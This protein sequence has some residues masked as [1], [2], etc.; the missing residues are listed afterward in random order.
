M[1]KNLFKRLQPSI[2]TPSEVVSGTDPIVV[3]R[4]E[5]TISRKQISKHALTVIYE[6][7]RAGH[8]AY[9]VGGGVRDLLRGKHPKD[10]DVATDAT[11]EQVKA[12]FQ[13]ARIVGRRAGHHR[14][15]VDPALHRFDQA[16]YDFAASRVC[17]G[18][19]S[20]LF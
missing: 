13:R 17:A 10:F 3:E 2:T 7:Q 5:H 20:V 19:R 14:E 11:P 12:L 4:D 15:R 9:L 1:L 8:E 18:S 16:Q 6:L